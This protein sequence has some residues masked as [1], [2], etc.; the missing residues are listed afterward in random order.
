M[1][2]ERLKRTV[3]EGHLFVPIV[4]AVFM[5]ILLLVT[6][7]NYGIFTDELYFYACALHPGFGYVDQPPFIG[8][9]TAFSLLF[10]KSLQVLRLFPALAGAGTVVLAASIARTLGGSCFAS[11]F[12]SLSIL[13]GNV[14]WVMFGYVSM[15]A[16]DI[17]FVTLAAYL[18]IRILQNG[19]TRLWMLMGIVVGL[20]LN[21]KLSMLVF[22]AGLL[23]GLLLTSSRKLFRTGDPYIAASI[24]IAMF[25][26]HIFW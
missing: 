7:G 5:F 4:L 3:I 2:P 19:S 21:T 1:M 16:Y 11:A 8:W 6:A 17:F 13:C 9:I 26:P 25:L 18:F 22:S 24:A 20:G 12:A 15:N 14:F 23:A 10:G